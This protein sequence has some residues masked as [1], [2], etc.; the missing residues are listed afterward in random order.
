MAEAKNVRAETWQARPGYP[1]PMQLAP[2]PAGLMETGR[3]QLLG[4]AMYLTRA[5]VSRPGCSTGGKSARPPLRMP[6]HNMRHDNAVN[7][8][9]SSAPWARAALAFARSLQLI[10]RFRCRDTQITSKARRVIGC[11]G[12]RGMPVAGVAAARLLSGRRPPTALAP[13][14]VNPGRA[15]EGTTSQRSPP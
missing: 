8:A 1:N 6:T 5:S 11:S 13:A 2:L 7:S 15:R 12:L 4:W 14:C 10:V 3:S 9:M